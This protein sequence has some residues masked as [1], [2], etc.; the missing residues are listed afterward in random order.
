[1]GYTGTVKIQA[2]QNYESVFYNVTESRQ[3][4]SETISD[5]FNVVGFH[6]LLRLAFNNSIG[7]GAAGNVQVTDNVVTSVNITNS[8]VYYVAPP[9]IE[10]LGD[11]SGAVATCT[12]SGGVVTSVTIVNGGSGYLPIQFQSNVSATALFTNGRVQNVQ[13]R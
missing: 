5:Y 4:L 12:V 9:L 10:I 11:G 3:Y 2:A 13:Y 7:Y 6:P 1:V 8:G